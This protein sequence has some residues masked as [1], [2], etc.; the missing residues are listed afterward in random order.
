MIFLQGKVL[1]DSDSPLKALDNHLKYQEV[2]S[3]ISRGEGFHIRLLGKERALYTAALFSFAGESFIF[4][5]GVSLAPLDQM[6]EKL[7]R[8]I[9]LYSLLI[10]LCV[11]LI[12]LWGAWSV[13]LPLSSVLK[14]IYRMKRITVSGEITKHLSSDD[15]WII[16][17]KALDKAEEG[18]KKYLDELDREN[19]KLT[20]VMESMSD[21]ILAIGLDENVLFANGQFKKKFLSKKIKR[22]D[23][24]KFKIWEISRH[25]KLQDLFHKAI[26]EAHPVHLENMELPVKGGKETKVFDVRINPLLGQT[27]GAFGAV[28][29]F[30]DIT[31]RRMAEKMREDFIINISHEVRTPLTAMKGF[32][33]ILKK[34]PWGSPGQILPRK[35]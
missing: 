30:Y 26:V 28:G 1:C 29:I 13:S 16:V 21:S 15:E 18:V 6:I 5:Q 24:S 11:F 31:E 9:V 19:E 35:N 7:N 23:L 20:T 12:C 14:K 2:A 22:E 3:A 8:S 25:M 10:L 27:G 4:R 17:E 33:Q 34:G 32:V